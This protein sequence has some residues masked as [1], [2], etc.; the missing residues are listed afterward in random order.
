MINFSSRSPVKN[1]LDKNNSFPFVWFTSNPVYA[2]KTSTSGSGDNYLTLWRNYLILCFGVA[3]P[4]I[5]SPGHLRASTP[6]IAAAA[7]PESGVS[8]DNKV[9]ASLSSDLI[10]STNA[11]SFRDQVFMYRACWHSNSKH[12]ITQQLP[13]MNGT[14]RWYIFLTVQTLLSVQPCV[15]VVFKH[16]FV[17]LNRGCL[18]FQ[19]IGSPSVA[20]LLKQLVP[21]MRAESIELTESLVLGFGR[22][23]SLIFRYIR[24][25]CFK[26]SKNFL[27][28][29][30][31][32][33][34]CFCMLLYRPW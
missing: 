6:E 30:G 23:N 5:M 27:C 25:L 34:C 3:K 4:S 11:L 19:V 32:M 7:T 22:T 33:T 1:S 15:I 29:R 13:Y 24:K 28:L 14:G 9:A 17:W 2:K 21:L 31:P 26:S 20:W 18:M 16:L 12:R 8:Y 10:H